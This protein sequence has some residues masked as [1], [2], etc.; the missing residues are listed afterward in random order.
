MFSER[1]V[2]VSHLII[3]IPELYERPPTNSRV[4]EALKTI[5]FCDFSSVDQLALTT[6]YKGTFDFYKG[7]RYFIF[8][9]PK[10]WSTKLQNDVT[11]RILRIFSIGWK[12]WQV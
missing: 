12:F 2:H 7:N 1:S 11:S 6:L 5:L 3:T 4:F 10:K 9:P 8:G